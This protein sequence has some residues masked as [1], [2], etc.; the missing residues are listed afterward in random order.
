[1]EEVLSVSVSALDIS[2]A[3]A[4]IE[5]RC[6]C[7]ERVVAIVVVFLAA[8]VMF[9]NADDLEHLQTRFARARLR[10]PRWIVVVVVL[11]V[12]VV[13]K[14]IFFFFFFFFSFSFPCGCT[15]ER[16]DLFG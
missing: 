16:R 15:D 12:G 5:I 4:A 13:A 8:L 1:M 9:Q 3:F 10:V 11:V 6:S 7:S 2:V 14:R